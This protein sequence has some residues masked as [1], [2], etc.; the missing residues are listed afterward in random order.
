ML[1]QRPPEKTHMCPG[2]FMGKI[3]QDPRVFKSNR[4]H[5]GI[6]WCFFIELGYIL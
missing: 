1:T 6:L 4:L 5:V 3:G 2:R